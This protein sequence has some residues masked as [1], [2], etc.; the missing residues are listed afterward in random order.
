MDEHIGTALVRGDKAKPLRTIEKLYTSLRHAA[1][2][3]FHRFLSTSLS[4]I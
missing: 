4:G 2:S 1:L 3:Q